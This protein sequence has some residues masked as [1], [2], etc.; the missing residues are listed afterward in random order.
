[1]LSRIISRK[2]PNLAKAA[3]KQFAY[4]SQISKRWFA[5]GESNVDKD[6]VKP[7]QLPQ[8]PEGEMPEFFKFTLSALH[9]EL[10]T[11]S[12]VRFIL[13]LLYLICIKMNGLYNT[14]LHY[15]Q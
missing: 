7:K 12:P 10:F 2:S 1:M 15:K 3:S 8:A 9:K 14:I 11:E 4:Q 5:E 13:W 6:S